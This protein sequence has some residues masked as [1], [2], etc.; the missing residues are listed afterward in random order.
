[1]FTTILRA[2]KSLFAGTT[3]AKASRP[4]NRRRLS[5]ECL[6]ER[7]CPA[8]FFVENLNDVGAGS[9]DQAVLDL[10]R[11]LDNENT[12]I[13]DE[14]LSG[15]ITTSRELHITKNVAIF[16]PCDGGGVT[17][18]CTSALSGGVDHRLFFIDRDVECEIHDLDLTGGRATNDVQGFG[19]MGGAIVNRGSL[20]LVNVEIYECMAAKDGGAIYTDGSGTTLVGC[21]LTT[22][23]AG[24]N[25]GAIS[26]DAGSVTIQSSQVIWNTAAERGGGLYL[27]G[28]AQA[29]IQLGTLFELNSAVYGGGIALVDQARCSLEESHVHNNRASYGGG[30]SVTGSLEEGEFCQLIVVNS[31]LMDNQATQQGG[32]LDLQGNNRTSLDADTLVYNNTA[33][34]NKGNGIYYQMNR[35]TLDNNAVMDQ[36]VVNNKQTADAW[37]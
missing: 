16:G 29:T 27:D 12:I 14:A 10:A 21:R 28:M 2:T 5:L 19:E 35:T 24:R 34:L 8:T 30:I 32:G 20:R 26:C 17:L 36:T 33:P 37:Q 7:D 1:M 6:E 4:S 22:N 15:T 11:S 31:S 3:K 18:A 9:L 23:T 13:F 25:G